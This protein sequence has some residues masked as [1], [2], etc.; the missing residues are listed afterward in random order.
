[1]NEASTAFLCA[2]WRPD[3]RQADSILFTFGHV[4]TS[5][6]TV[7]ADSGGVVKKQKE[8]EREKKSQ[9]RLKRTIWT[10]LNRPFESTWLKLL[11][12]VQWTEDGR[13]QVENNTH[14]LPLKQ[15]A[16]RRLPL[17]NAQSWCITNALQERSTSQWSIRLPQSF[18][19]QNMPLIL[20]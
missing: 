12:R 20:K 5:H 2:I 17:V 14:F 7:I 13:R 11:Y 8:R 3:Y 4:S 16:E 1:M 9:H 19:S 18:Q 15:S 10:Q 6:L